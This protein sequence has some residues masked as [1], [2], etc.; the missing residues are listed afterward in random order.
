MFAKELIPEVEQEITEEQKRQA[1]SRIKDLL[2]EKENCLRRL[3]SINDL[4][5]LP[6]NEFLKKY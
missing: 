2:R 5:E 1:K 4:L 3:E 6:V